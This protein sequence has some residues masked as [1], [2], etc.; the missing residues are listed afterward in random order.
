[1]KIKGLID[2]DLVNYRLCS[3][4]IVFP[5]CSFKC[6]KDKCQNY[7]ALA[8][9][10]TI[11]MKVED[12]CERYKNNSLS[13]ALVLAGLE[14]FDSPFDLMSLIDC[15]RNKYEIEDDIVIYTGYT[16]EDFIF[17]IQP[18]LSTVYSNITKYKNI[19]VKFGGYIPG[20]K[21]HFDEIL[22]VNLASDN[23]YAKRIS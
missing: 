18:A 20:D 15:F 7:L 21:P 16:E 11:D 4:Y 2:E 22:G 10:P 6:G 17:G 23:Q 12:I 8:N 19:I 14:P 3:M 13:K 1:M 5:K 9:T